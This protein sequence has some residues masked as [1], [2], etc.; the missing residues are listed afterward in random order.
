MK[1]QILAVAVLGL[2][3]A[4]PA[5]AAK[6]DRGP[7]IYGARVGTSTMLKPD[8]AAGNKRAAGSP[9]ATAAQAKAAAP[10][11]GGSKKKAAKKSGVN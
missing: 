7:V 11:P 4:M 6:T 5:F 8:S 3:F 1:R 2:G 9:Q 10:A